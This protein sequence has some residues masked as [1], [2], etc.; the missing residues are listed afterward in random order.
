[1]NHK[2]LLPAAATVL[3]FAVAGCSSNSSIAPTTAATPKPTATTLGSPVT[4]IQHVIVI[5]GENISYDHYFGTY[6]AVA[7]SAA[8]PADARRERPH[9]LPK[10]RTAPA[11]NNLVAPL[12]PG[13]WAAVASPTLLD[14]EPEQRHRLGRGL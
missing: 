2:L 5:F 13:T 1:M 4:P 9:E 8:N 6:P 12:N 11:N 10:R 7:Y 14:R 3:T